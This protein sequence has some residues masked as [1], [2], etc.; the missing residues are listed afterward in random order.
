[1]TNCS[2]RR[3]NGF[4]LIELLVTIVIIAIGLLGVATMF[5][6]G[7]TS[8]LYAQYSVIATDAADQK[9]EQVRSAG[10]NSINSANFPSPFPVP[11]LPEGEGIISWEPYPNPTSNNQYKVTVEVHWGGGRRVSGRVLHETIVS[12]RP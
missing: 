9:L 6:Y 8:R 4:S 1:M 11:E 7:M 10:Y 5:L 12:N 3:A 2:W